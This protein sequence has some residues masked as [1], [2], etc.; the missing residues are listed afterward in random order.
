MPNYD[1]HCPDCE[2]TFELNIPMEHRDDP[3]RIECPSCHSHHHPKRV[4]S[5]VK[6]QYASLK[7]Q[8]TQAGGGWQEVQAK[9]MEK[10]GLNQKSMKGRHNI[11]MR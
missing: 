11:K 5:A 10:Q 7:S 3:D 8:L 6:L 4:V 1:Y 9:I 2:L